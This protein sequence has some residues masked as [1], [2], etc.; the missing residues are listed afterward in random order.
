[1]GLKQNSSNV[2]Y[3]RI[4]EGNFYLS[5]DLETPYTDLE[6]Q[7]V[8]LYFRDDKFNDQVIKK[9]NVVLLDGDDKYVL[10]F[11][12]DSSY[13]TSFLGFLK[14]ADLTKPLTL[15]IKVKE[16]KD[17]KG[18][19]KTRRSVLISQGGQWLKSFY[20]NTTGELMPE[21]KQVRVSGKVL[22][23]KT[24]L[25]DFMEKLVNEEFKPQLTKERPKVS[26]ASEK[27]PVKAA[28]PWEADEDVADETDD[29]LPF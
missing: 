9:L 17:K 14:N 13:S 11:P 18:E 25:L 22:W 19:S 2:Q 24:D 8:D 4:K 29:D 1:M 21:I 5:T 10:S 16:Y 20:S 15:S 28:L 7:I 26:F 27:V 6:G 3:V 23:D 12:F